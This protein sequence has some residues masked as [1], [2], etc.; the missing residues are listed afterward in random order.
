MSRFVIIYLTLSG[1]TKKIAEAIAEGAMSQELS[2]TVVNF[3][4]TTPK[5]LCEAEVV[6]IGSPTY[7]HTM[8]GQMKKFM[9]GL[10][11]MNGKKGV[12][13]G[14]YG[15]SGEAPRHIANKMRDLGIHVLDPVVRIQ[16]EPDE[17]EIEA[18]KLL[19]KD[20]A[21]RLKNIERQE[22]MIPG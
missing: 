9:D 15:W 13:F 3:Q 10:H 20:V 7:M 6:G 14:S 19:G 18:C 21:I 1:N 12:A 2:T 4:D 8:H 22:Y 16:Y 11:S 17:K 5:L